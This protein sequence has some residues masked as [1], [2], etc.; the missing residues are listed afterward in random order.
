MMNVIYEWQLTS[1]ERE[2]GMANH[3]ERQTRPVAIVTGAA[4]GIGEATARALQAAGYRVFGTSRKAAAGP[5]G[6]TMLVCDVTDEGSVQRMVA[7][8][9]GPTGLLEDPDR[10]LRT[11][12]VRRAVEPREPGI[13]TEVDVEFAE[14][15]A[16]L[17]ARIR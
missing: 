10:H 14:A 13:V 17:K 3:Q 12:P 4:G 7:E 6:I 11:A 9:G 16:K 8:L 1:T 2:H 15:P 5:D